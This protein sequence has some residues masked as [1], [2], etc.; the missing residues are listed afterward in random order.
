MRTHAISLR[1]LSVVLALMLVL[2][3]LPVM[4]LAADTTTIY[5]ENTAN[6]KNVKIYYWGSGYNPVGWP[7]SNMKLVDGNIYSFDV[8][9]GCN[10]VIFNNGSGTQTDDLP[11]PTNGDNLYVHNSGWSTYDPSGT[12]EHAWDDGSVTTAPGCLTAGEKVITCTKCGTSYNEA[13]PAVGHNFDNGVC[14]ACGLSETRT[15]YFENG[16]NWETV[17]AYFWNDAGNMTTWPGEPMTHVAGALWSIVISSDA[18]LIIFNDGTS[19]TD[20]LLLPADKDK[21]VFGADWTTYDPDSCAHEW[22][23]G[24]VVTAAT[25]QNVGETIYTCG[26]CGNTRSVE[27]PITKHSYVDGVCS[28]CG[29]DKPI[30][31]FYL[32]GYINGADYGCQ[33]DF[34]NM[35]EYKFVDG[36]LV[37]TFGIDSYV[38]VKTEGNAN[39][40]L[41]ESY[42]TDTTA[43]LVE[44]AS[45]KMLVPGGVE[46]TF[47]LVENNDG[48]LTLSY[49]TATPVCKHPNH[50]VDGVCTDCGATVDHSYVDGACSVCG[51]AEPADIFYLYGFINSADYTGTDYAFVDGSVT[52]NFDAD[53]YI[54]VCTSKGVY[55]MAESYISETSGL[56]YVA[57]ETINEKMFVPGNVDVTFTLV[58]NGDGS[59]SISY[60]TSGEACQH[61]EHNTDGICSNCGKTVEHTYVDGACSICGVAAPVVDYYL[62]GHI[63]GANYGCDEDWENLGQYKFVDGKLTA[64]FDQ[65][66]YVFIKTGDN[67]NWYMFESYVSTTSGTLYTTS[68]G[69]SEKMLIPANKEITFTLVVNED[70][71]LTLSYVAAEAPE[72]TVSGTI[73]S[74]GSATDD[75]TVELLQDG[76][77]VYST[78]VTGKTAAYAITDVAIGSYTLKISKNAHVALE[79]AVTVEADV[80]QDA[81]I[82]LVGDANCDGKVNMKDWSR[83]YDHI[84]ETDELTDYNLLCADT[85]RDGKVNMKDWSR[86]YDHISE[87]NPL[88]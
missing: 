19:Q 81:K 42:C 7:G 44:N 25:C 14:T 66:S 78:V 54:F 5:F 15:V 79:L 88:W 67:A 3:M 1:V 30:L 31:A 10:M 29:I 47:T 2:G 59:L 61:T 51:A 86:L 60:T 57:S 70:G 11:M 80:A 73:T 32:V 20:D 28:V 39:W 8:P 43:T 38:Y 27:T 36:K 9:S 72:Y 24:E 85:N 13:V 64:T 22:D 87:T 46:L 84:G 23:E 55:Y 49:T 68:N 50:N 77:V 62:I 76:V 40:Y 12:C 58:D 33:G 53:S 52:V 75:V 35:G 65:D 56:L 82:C 6:W 37:A 4:A 63:N 83:L 74:F 16:A 69:T 48:T 45:E 41:C 21:F 71:S 17:N 26:I 34:E 18:K